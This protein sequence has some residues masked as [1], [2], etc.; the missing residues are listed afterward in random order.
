MHLDRE[1]RNLERRCDT[2]VHSIKLGFKMYCQRSEK[3]TYDII[4][5]SPIIVGRKRADAER[6]IDSDIVIIVWSILNLIMLAPI[7]ALFVCC[8]LEFKLGISWFISYIVI[9]CVF[10]IYRQRIKKIKCGRHARFW[11]PKT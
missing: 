5:G 9:E 8:A 10:L 6:D 4:D 1:I 2:C 3:V 11:T 7:L